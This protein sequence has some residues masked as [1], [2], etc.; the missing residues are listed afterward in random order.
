MAEKRW[1]EIL[2]RPRGQAT[3]RHSRFLRGREPAERFAGRLQ[4]QGEGDT[5]VRKAYLA[6]ACYLRLSP[7]KV[8]LVVDLIRDRNVQEAIQTLRFTKKGATREVTKVLRSAV[9]NAE[10]KEEDVDVDR[11]F[12]STAYVNEGSRSKRF[13]AAPMGRAHRYQRRQCHI[14][15]AVAEKES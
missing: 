13:R 9:A 5:R 1:Y 14:L 10:Q 12:V 6:E 3:W 4:K 2:R 11:L 15:I 7:Q 8:R